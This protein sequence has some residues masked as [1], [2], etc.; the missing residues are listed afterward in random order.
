MA[1]HIAVEGAQV[2]ELLPV[3]SGHFVQHGAFEMHDFVV[4]EGQHKILGKGVNE[5]ERN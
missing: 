5:T 3:I 2:G 1:S 4:A